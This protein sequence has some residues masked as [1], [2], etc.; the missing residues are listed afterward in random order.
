MQSSYVIVNLSVIPLDTIHEAAFISSIASIMSLNSSCVKLAYEA[1]QL[2]K[3]K[4]ST[5]GYVSI[6]HTVTTIGWSDASWWHGNR[7]GLVANLT[8]TLLFA[9]VSGG[10]TAI[11]RSKLNG[12]GVRDSLK[13][14]IVAVVSGDTVSLPTAAPTESIHVEN[15]PNATKKTSTQQAL[16]TGIITG[17]FAFICIFVP[18][19]ILSRKH[20]LRKK[21]LKSPSED[22][23][24]DIFSTN[25]NISGQN[26]M[27][28]LQ[29]LKSGQ[30][31]RLERE[32]ERILK[33]ES[34]VAVV[35]MASNDNEHIGS[36]VDFQSAYDN[37][38]Q[39]SIWSQSSSKHHGAEQSFDDWVNSLNVSPPSRSTSS[40]GKLI[41]FL[42]IPIN[43]SKNT[44]PDDESM[45][46][47][48][49]E[50]INSSF[51]KGQIAKPPGDSEH[52][53]SE[54]KKPSTEDD[55]ATFNSVA[56]PDDTMERTSSWRLRFF[57]FAE[58][59]SIPS[60]D[61]LDDMLTMA[62]IYPE[63]DLPEQYLQSLEDMKLAAGVSSRRDTVEEDVEVD[64]DVDV[65]MLAIYPNLEN[66]PLPD[67][68]SATVSV[69]S[70]PL[71]SG[72]SS[73]VANMHIFVTKPTHL[74]SPLSPA[75]SSP[76]RRRGIAEAEVL[77]AD[78][79]LSD[80]ADIEA[81]EG[82]DLDLGLDLDLDLDLD[83]R[84]E[85]RDPAEGR[86]ESLKATS[87]ADTVDRGVV[88]A[89]AVRGLSPFEE[90]VEEG[91]EEEEPQAA[92]V[93]AV[94]EEELPAV[95][96]APKVRYTSCDDH[97]RS[98]SIGSVTEESFF[99]SPFSREGSDNEEDDDVS[100]IA[101]HSSEWLSSKDIKRFKTKETLQQCRPNSFLSAVDSFSASQDYYDHFGGLNYDEEGYDVKSFSIG[102]INASQFSPHSTK[103]TRSS[104]QVSNLLLKQTFSARESNEEQ[105]AF[106]VVGDDDIS[107]HVH[108]AHHL[109]EH[110][111]GSIVVMTTPPRSPDKL[112]FVDSMPSLPSSSLLNQ[113]NDLVDQSHG[114][115]FRAI[116]MKFETMI[117]RNTKSS[118]F[119]LSPQQIAQ[120]QLER[121][122]KRSR[123]DDISKSPGYYTGV[124]G[125]D[126][127]L[128]EES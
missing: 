1:D 44:E 74:F 11:F 102:T 78:N 59:P 87:S 112:V 57:D 38:N 82:V 28:A 98:N 66:D 32:S 83:D 110:S 89:E 29:Q 113:P 86:A 72:R 123:S 42:G 64:V 48:S 43:S 16:L 84:D 27:S 104:P 108:S 8:S 75:S 122:H 100:V 23:L 53:Q 73:P 54:V 45:G 41:P 124:F 128:L 81:R 96:T 77:N 20:L 127:E 97:Q 13:P 65:D 106:L 92:V 117:Q 7:S 76:Q 69:R 9:V 49:Y 24:Y 15:N 5:N 60:Q 62:D 33:S 52:E 126:I 14:S 18:I 94:Y 63:Y 91:R 79:P 50:D 39:R 34:N 95:Y 115:K 88:V 37:Q 85:G 119:S 51:D 31:R 109:E 93:S 4:L 12:L 56:K 99:N 90:D 125:E 55:F 26:K 105:P 46:V 30:E 118:S 114:T 25:E 2:L 10:A 36:P 103:W 61:K 17:V 107:H 111:S 35:E 19:V 71:S 80:E 121:V 6:Q 101:H 21:K 67:L 22:F 120:Y 58:S 3:R 70:T 68:A 47:M 116:K 40:D